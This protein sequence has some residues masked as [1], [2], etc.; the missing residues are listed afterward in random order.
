LNI[1]EFNFYRS[2]IPTY[3]WGQTTT[4]IIISVDAPDASSLSHTVSP[5]GHVL[6]KG[7]VPK[8]GKFELS[9][10][11][12]N[13][14]LA[15]DV[16]AN[17][18]PRSIQLRIPKLESGKTWKTLQKSHI[19]K[20]VQEKRDFDYFENSD[21]E[22]GESAGEEER[23]PP[24]KGLDN[25]TKEQIRRVREKMKKDGKK[26]PANEGRE[27]Y[28][29][30]FPEPNGWDFLI[31]AVALLHIY[32]SPYTKVEESFN[33]QATH[34]FLFHRTALSKYDHLEFPGVV[35]RTFLGA[36]CTALLA[37]PLSLL[38][39]VILAPKIIS[40][41][42]VRIVISLLS[43][44]SLSSFRFQL[45]KKFG[46]K[47]AAAFSIITSAQ[48]HM[49]FYASRPLPNTYAA[50]LVNFAFAFWLQEQYHITLGILAFAAAVFRSELVILGI[51]I[52]LFAVV[53]GRLGPFPMG[54]IKVIGYGLAAFA[55]GLAVTVLFDSIFWQR[56][57]W[58]EGEGLYFNVVLN[59]SHEWGTEPIYWYFVDAMPRAMLATIVFV[60]GGLL[61]NVRIRPFAFPIITFISLFSLLP[62]KELRFVMYALP[63]LNAVAAVELV[64]IYDDQKKDRWHKYFFNGAMSVLVMTVFGNFG[65]SRA[66]ANNY[67]G[68]EALWELHRIERY[69]VSRGA[70]QP[71]VHIDVAAA[72]QGVSRFGELGPPWRWVA[73]RASSTCGRD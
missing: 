2:Y 61:W 16:R 28:F 71:Y 69:N 3:K 15:E 45:E 59:K 72:Q 20:P 54:P 49:L 53:K 30:F 40:L 10:Q 58:P 57:L 60:P 18:L 4:H 35:P 9:L 38:F 19:L 13:R 23:K 12:L 64:R 36:A 68:G 67:P 73:P 21:S 24:S 34:D 63:I 41:Y 46:T 11:L 56:L 39:E 29:G 14:V 55:S 33:L 66:S 47:V 42:I 1:D 50:V 8:K 31:L 65:F 51:P 48:F 44:A 7:E 62:H 43:V 17:T 32:S 52:F 70:L 5:D 22:S 27:L 37:A 6:V 25:A 26:L